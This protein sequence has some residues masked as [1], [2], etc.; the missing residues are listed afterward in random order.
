MLVRRQVDSCSSRADCSPECVL[1]RSA[2]NDDTTLGGNG[3]KLL[4]RR[5]SPL[6]L[7]ISLF[8]REILLCNCCNYTNGVTDTMIYTAILT[9]SLSI[10]SRP[11]LYP[12]L[13]SL[14]SL[15]LKAGG[16][17]C[18]IGTFLTSTLL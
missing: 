1:R 2:E 12:P 9:P 10:P 16:L 8:G 18:P 4:V 6:Q 3:A 11:L 5:R 13:P 15:V 14:H 7:I 17:A